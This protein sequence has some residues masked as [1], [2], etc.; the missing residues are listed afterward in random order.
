MRPSRRS[1]AGRLRVRG[2]AALARGLLVEATTKAAASETPAPANLT[3]P[4]EQRAKIRDRHRSSRSRS[5]A[6]RA[7]GTVA[8]DGDRPTQVLA[9]ISGPV[10]RLLVNVGRRGHRGRAAREHRR[11]PTSAPRSPTIARRR[12]RRATPS[13]SPI[14]TSSSSRTTRSRAR[15]LEQAEA[16]AVS[17]EA[18]RDAALDA[19]ARARRRRDDAR[20][21]P[22][23][24]GRSAAAKAL[25]RSPIDGTVVEKLITPGQLLQAGTTPCF[26]VA[27]LSTVWVMA[28]VFESDLPLRRDRRPADITHR[29]APR[30]RCPGGS[31]TSP[32]GRSGHAGRR[33]CASSREQPERRPQAGHVRARRAS[34]RAGTATGC[35]C[36]SPRS[37]ATT[38]TCPFVY[39]ANAGRHAS[40]AGGS[41]SARRSAIV[42]DPRRVSRPAIRSSSRAGSSCSSRR[43]SEPS[44]TCRPRRRSAR[45]R[46]RS[47]TASSRRRCASASSS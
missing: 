1:L 28:N 40:R 37:C 11:R 14:S 12:R 34:I 27:D 39:V 10:A 15:D 41:T 2:V 7:T 22:A 45:G 13:A 24:A 4:A 23:R 19:A 3:L 17:A 26:T 6:R 21:H 44:R 42:R 35:S 43:A 47:S 38:R 31:T 30:R 36:R 33:P 29:G 32:P 8:F 20:R 25:I 16:D 9:P 46:R 18:D 5:A